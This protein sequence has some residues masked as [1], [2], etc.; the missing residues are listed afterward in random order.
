MRSGIGRLVRGTLNMPSGAT[1]RTGGMGVHHRALRQ[2]MRTDGFTAQRVLY[3]RSIA[4]CTR[5]SCSLSVSRGAGLTDA[6]SLL[7]AEEDDDAPIG[8]S[9]NGTFAYLD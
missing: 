3:A 1:R 4:L 7:W 2:G 6:C 9:F 8:L 5:S